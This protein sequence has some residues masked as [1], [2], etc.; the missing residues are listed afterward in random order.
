[1]SW[2]SDLAKF[3]RTQGRGLALDLAL[4]A[5]LLVLA[6]VA[7]FAEDA[8][9]R[10]KQLA[11]AVRSGVQTAVVR[12]PTAEALS[13]LASAIRA[14]APKS[15][16]TDQDLTV[17]MLCGFPSGATA[18]CT[19]ADLGQVAFVTIR[20]SETWRPA[21]QLPLLPKELPLLAGLTLSFR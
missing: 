15:P 12:P 1:M 7:G 21:L 5:P 14:A 19:D 9:N 20:L 10:Q 13:D 16:N 6:L 3:A 8:M 18:R 4:T 2:L 11:S 17:E